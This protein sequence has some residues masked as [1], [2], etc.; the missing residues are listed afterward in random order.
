M[1]IGKSW[2]H[3]QH[4]GFV[5]STCLVPGIAEQCGSKT[6]GPQDNPVAA[7][8]GNG[9]YFGKLELCVQRQGLRWF[10][11]IGTE[12]A[13]A[14]RGEKLF[15]YPAGKYTFSSTIAL[16]SNVYQRGEATS[17]MAKKGSKP[18]P[19]LHALYFVAPLVNT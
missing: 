6:S 5:E 10:V 19:Y 18:G 14:G 9:T 15:Y 2:F 17:A 13:V 1:K 8:Y 12:A 11:R 4:Q 16:D 3:Q 7:L